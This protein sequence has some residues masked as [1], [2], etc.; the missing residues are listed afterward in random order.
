MKKVILDGNYTIFSD[1]RIYSNK[2]N[3]FMKQNLHHT[4]YLRVY[5]KKREYR[6]HRLVAEAFIPNPN[7][8]PMINHINENKQDNRIENLE[9]C[10]N[11]YNIC[12][13]IHRENTGI[14]WH[15]GKYDVRIYH[16]KKNIYLGRYVTIEEA[17]KV[18]TDY[19]RLHNL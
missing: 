14:Y 1:G 6:I 15:K 10:N 5:I 18:R 2:R 11:R 8:F 9:W 4:G 17:I 12:F 13:S 7:N 16:N 3:K 19:I